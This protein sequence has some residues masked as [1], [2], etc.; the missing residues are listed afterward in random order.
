MR[1]ILASLGALMLGIFGSL[2]LAAPASA[3]PPVPP[4]LS[5]QS[6][7][8]TAT[9][10]V[11]QVTDAKPGSVVTFSYDR[12]D[13]AGLSGSMT[14]TA[15]ADGT[16]VAT[17]PLTE[18]GTYSV[19]ATGIDQADAPFTVSGI[20]AVAEAGTERRRLRRRQ[21]RRRRLYRWWHRLLRR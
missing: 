1:R 18:A 17:L 14:A 16:A 12:T 4:A 19:V 15:D 8:T 13:A 11:V 7:G 20:V 2:A 5:I 6:G 10:T 21:Y 3:Y 9:G